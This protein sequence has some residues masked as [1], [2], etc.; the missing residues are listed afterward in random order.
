MDFGTDQ[1]HIPKQL[2]YHETVGV[3]DLGIDLGVWQDRKEVLLSLL[4]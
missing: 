4:Q 2:Y 3:S 1:V